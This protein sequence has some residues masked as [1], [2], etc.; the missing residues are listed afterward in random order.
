MSNSTD[1]TAE[2]AVF[3]LL[4]EEQRDFFLKEAS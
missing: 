4:H 3:P 2:I 1:S